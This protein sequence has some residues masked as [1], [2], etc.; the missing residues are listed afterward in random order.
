MDITTKHRILVSIL[1]AHVKEDWPERR[2]KK[3]DQVK[4]FPEKSFMNFGQYRMIFLEDRSLH[5][6][7]E[8]VEK[9]I[10]LNVCPKPVS[11]NDYR[12]IHRASVSD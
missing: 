9:Y 11:L 2:L 8:E 5:I 12:E 3:N 6:T 4:V 1:Q 7:K 10:S